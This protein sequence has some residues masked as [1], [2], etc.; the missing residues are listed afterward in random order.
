MADDTTSLPRL[1]P[2]L[3]LSSHPGRVKR[4][5]VQDDHAR[6]LALLLLRL[7][8]QSV[9]AVLNLSTAVR[10]LD[11]GVLQPLDFPFQAERADEVDPSGRPPSAPHPVVVLVARTLA[12]PGA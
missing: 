11:Q 4:R 8:D 5:V 3:T 6:R 2:F 10:A 12:R 1:P 7:L 9:Q